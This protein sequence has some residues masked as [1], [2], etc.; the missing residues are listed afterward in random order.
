MVHNLDSSVSGLEGQI[1]QERG[2]YLDG[3]AKQNQNFFVYERYA[4]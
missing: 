4:S 3:K 1:K 2:L